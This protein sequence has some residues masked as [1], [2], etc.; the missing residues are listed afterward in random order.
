MLERHPDSS[1]RRVVF[2]QVSYKAQR[3][4]KA[5]NSHVH[6]ALNFCSRPS[7][8]SSTK[9]TSVDRAPKLLHSPDSALRRQ[10][11]RKRVQILLSPVDALQGCVWREK[12][13]SKQERRPRPT[14]RSVFVLH[15]PS[16]RHQLGRF[17]FL[18]TLQVFFCQFPSVPLLRLPVQ[19]EHTYCRA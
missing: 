7:H 16:I 9:R 17:T 12:I 8:P 1:Q 11:E 6:L 3:E 4:A 13:A 14:D 5:A 15:L 19:F 18:S 10:R 2:P